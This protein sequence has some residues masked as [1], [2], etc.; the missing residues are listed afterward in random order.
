[1]RIILDPKAHNRTLFKAGSSFVKL[2][3]GESYK[4]SEEEISRVVHFVCSNPDIP[5]E[6]LINVSKIANQ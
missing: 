2:L 4:P 3:Y 1:M 5:L 6:N